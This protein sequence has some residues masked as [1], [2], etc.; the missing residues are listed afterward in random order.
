[1]QN[2]KNILVLVLVLLLAILIFST[3][4]L[5]E[6]YKQNLEEKKSHTSGQYKEDERKKEPDEKNSA[7][8]SSE[9]STLKSL[10]GTVKKGG[11]N[12]L[13]VEFQYEDTSWQSRV[14]K[15]EKTI[16]GIAPEDDISMPQIITLQDIQVGDKVIISSQKN[17]FNK[18]SF[19][20]SGIMTTK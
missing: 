3:V 5:Q 17:I 16:I 14:K 18:E 19:F 20:A 11:D 13:T 2:K 12:Y 1:M 8:K 9:T 4:I 15:N 10:Q 6:K 7:P